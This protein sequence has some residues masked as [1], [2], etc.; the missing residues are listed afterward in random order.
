MRIER[1][2]MILTDAS[3]LKSTGQARVEDLSVFKVKKEMKKGKEHGYWHAAWARAKKAEELGIE[4]RYLY[5]G[6][7]S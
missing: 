5:I 3:A 2:E 7:N 6:E 4:K 1:R